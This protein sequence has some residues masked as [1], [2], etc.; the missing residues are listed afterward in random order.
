MNRVAII[1]TLFI[2]S[3]KKIIS[4][5]SEFLFHLSLPQFVSQLFYLGR[6]VFLVSLEFFLFTL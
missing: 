5:I 3:G 2:I 1:A 6:K 4:F